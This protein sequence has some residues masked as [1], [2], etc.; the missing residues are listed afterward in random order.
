MRICSPQLGL[1]PQSILGGEIY[2]RQILK[3]LA[4]LG[5]E[6]EICLPLFKPYGKVRGWH[7]RYI[8]IPFVIPPYVYNLWVLPYL[9]SQYKR[10]PFEILRIHSPGFIGLAG[11]IF[12]KMFPRVKLVTVHH[13]LGEGGWVERIIDPYLLP[14]S[15]VIICDSFRTKEILEQSNTKIKGKVWTIHNGVDEILRPKKKSKKLLRDL[16]IPSE[17]NVLF[18]MGLFIKRKNPFFLLPIL[19]KVQ[20]KYP[21]THLIFCGVGSLKNQL[22]EDAESLN[23]AKNVHIVGPV[24]AEKKCELMNLADIYVHPAVNEGFSLAVIEAMACGIPVIITDGFSAQEAVTDGREGF[25]CKTEEEWVGKINLLLKNSRL[26]KR[27]KAASLKKVK[28]E[29]KWDIAAKKHL[30]LFQKLLR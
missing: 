2:D 1:S 24:F 12:K 6:V 30:S 5:V 19:K 10:M 22:I 14:L 8:P 21:N 16:G 29:F 27:M 4:N 3:Y 25:I 20:M 17:A 28:K 18:F 11:I 13:W 15:D 9:I 7:V 26:K 23:L